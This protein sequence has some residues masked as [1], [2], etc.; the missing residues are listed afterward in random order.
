MCVC[1]NCAVPQTKNT[2]SYTVE[3]CVCSGAIAIWALKCVNRM[4]RRSPFPC[5][6]PH[7][8]IGRSFTEEARPLKGSFAL[9][10]GVF[11]PQWRLAGED[12]C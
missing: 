2:T 1:V 6:S 11:S 5:E 12:C 10:C 4:G 8:T 7:R 9:E 3:H